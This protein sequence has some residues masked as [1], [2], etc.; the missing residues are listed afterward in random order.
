MQKRF[1]AAV[2][3]LA[4]AVSAAHPASAS[5]SPAA[6]NAT[7]DE[8][9]RIVDSTWQKGSVT[10]KGD[11]VAEF[12]VQVEGV[13][14]LMAKSNGRYEFVQEAFSQALD[15]VGSGIGV[16]VSLKKDAMPMFHLS[17]HYNEQRWLLMTRVSVTVD[18]V[19]VIDRAL[20]REDRL[21]Q[22]RVEDGVSERYGFVPDASE[23]EGLRRIGPKSK[24]VIRLKGEKGQKIVDKTPTRLFQEAVIKEL[25]A[26]DTMS[27]ALKGHI[28]PG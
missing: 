15:N 2:M 14:P 27:A 24:V 18:G 16:F 25:A 1:I 5:D 6:G 21:E 28:P 10:N 17:P 13:G 9:Q 12:V 3:A 11:G 22:G 20:T 26:Y 19:T 7:H 8:W 23:L 4:G